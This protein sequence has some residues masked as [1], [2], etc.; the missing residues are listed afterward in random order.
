VGADL[1]SWWREAY[2]A[3]LERKIGDTSLRSGDTLGE[4]LVDLI[5]PIVDVLVGRV[6]EVRSTDT[7]EET[8]KWSLIS[9]G[10]VSLTIE[11]AGSRR[12]AREEVSRLTSS[13]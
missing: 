1:K 2:L 4:I 11:L 3:V 6:E 7:N 5:N 13:S 10:Q 9:I 8:T 12:D